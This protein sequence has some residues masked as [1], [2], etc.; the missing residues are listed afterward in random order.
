MSD[1]VTPFQNVQEMASSFALW[2][3]HHGYAMGKEL[4]VFRESR[5]PV[6][7]KLNQ[8]S[9]ESLRQILLEVQGPK[10]EDLRLWYPSRWR[11]IRYR[12]ELATA[13][14]HGKVLPEHREVHELL[15]QAEQVDLL[16][17]VPGAKYAF[18]MDEVRYA[19]M[20]PNGGY[21]LLWLTEVLAWRVEQIPRIEMDEDKRTKLQTFL[22]T[23][24]RIRDC[25]TDGLLPD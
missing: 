20:S 3:I 15:A 24:S 4:W 21:E 1:L 13:M 11:N 9:M 22:D 25:L 5:E 7:L 10:P 6:P 14:L 16:E 23:L 17:F 8:G 19:T 18:Y 2:G 12:A